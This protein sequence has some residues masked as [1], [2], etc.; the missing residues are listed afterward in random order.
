VA[1]AAPA[2]P[3]QPVREPREFRK[4]PFSAEVF[5]FIVNGTDIRV[6]ID[7][8]CHLHKLFRSMNMLNNTPYVG[9]IQVH[10]RL[11]GWSSMI[12]AF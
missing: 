9:A 7:L 1:V 11:A 6:L 10:R 12:T 8:F 3:L 5:W 4:P 2:K